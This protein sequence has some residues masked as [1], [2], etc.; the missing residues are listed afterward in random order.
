MPIKITTLNVNGLRSAERRGFRSWLRRARPDVLCL[1]EIRCDKESLPVTL[2]RPRGWQVGWHPAQK[3]GYAGTAVWA[4]AAEVRFTIGSGHA[5][6][7]AEGRAVCAHL[8]ELDVWSLYM[9]SGSAGPERQAWK[10]E[11]MEHAWDFFARLRTSGRPTILCGDLNIAHKPIDL[12]NWRGNQKNSGFLPEE[13][14]F[15]DRLLASGWRDLF[16]ERHPDKVAYSWWSNRGQA[17]QKDVGWRLDYVLGTPGI[18]VVE[19]TIEKDAGL[20]DHAPVSAWIEAAPV[21][22]EVS[23]TKT[24]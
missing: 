12:K 4:R 9:P 18:S 8:P 7:D 2:W 1:Q 10:F 13:R 22:G 17:R 11:F 16:R 19:C 23:A 3:K 21:Y 20:S 5:R 15:M 24:A 14:A 6:G